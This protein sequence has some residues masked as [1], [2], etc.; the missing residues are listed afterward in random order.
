MVFPFFSIIFLFFFYNHTRFFELKKFIIGGDSLPTEKSKFYVVKICIAVYLIF[1]ILPSVFAIIYRGI[2]DTVLTA[3][4]LLQQRG[5]IFILLSYGICS[6]IMVKYMKER[7]DFSLQQSAALHWSKALRQKIPMLLLLGVGFSFFVS[8]MLSML[9]LPAEMMKDYDINVKSL[10]TGSLPW[11]SYLYV[12][13]LAPITEEILF[14]GFFTE[15]LKHSYAPWPAVMI[16][17]LLFAIG[18]GQIVW[19]VYAFLMG[20]VLSFIAQKSGTIYSSI[21]VHIGFNTA[22]LLPLLFQ[23]NK[24][25]QWIFGQKFSLICFTVLGIGIILFSSLKL[26]QK[27]GVEL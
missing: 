1:L 17:S 2:S 8:A 23:N 13:A 24:I 21:F 26:Q 4:E 19:I 27:G 25:Y 14:R 9:P 11:F 16:S 10:F 6:I 18:H 3:T 7:L 20:V 5:E 12:M 22:S 15:I